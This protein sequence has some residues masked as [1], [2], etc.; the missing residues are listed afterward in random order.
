MR[1]IIMRAILPTI[2]AAQ[3]DRI[4]LCGPLMRNLWRKLEPYIANTLYKGA[5]F[6]SINELA[7]QL[8]DWL[9]AGDVVLVKSSYSSRLSTIVKLLSSQRTI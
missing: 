4:L 3:P 1:N 5:W 9:T 6:G 8:G 7:G 2:L